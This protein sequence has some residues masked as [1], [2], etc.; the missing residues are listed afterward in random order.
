MVI[1]KLSPLFGLRIFK[2]DKVELRWFRN[3]PYLLTSLV[4]RHTKNE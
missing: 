2:M 1:R 3:A 4:A